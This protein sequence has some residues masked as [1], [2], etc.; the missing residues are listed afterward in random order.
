MPPLAAVIGFALAVLGLS[1]VVMQSAQ[2]YRVVQVVG[3]A[4]LIG[5]GA[6][7]LLRGR[8]VSTAARPDELVRVHTAFLMNL[9]NPK[10]AAVY[11][12]L[13]PQFLDSDAFTVV[14][15]LVLAL[16]HAALMACWLTASAT[17]L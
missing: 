15:V 11:L 16:V 10:A 8:R 6:T 14:N 9:L 5:L 12:T 13:A 7:S 17:V 3:A 1:V 2:V 4:Y